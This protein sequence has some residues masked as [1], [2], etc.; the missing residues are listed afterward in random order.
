[1]IL[2]PAQHTSVL[3]EE[4]LLVVH[5]NYERGNIMIVEY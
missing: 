3:F 2:S 4:R 1:M 5:L